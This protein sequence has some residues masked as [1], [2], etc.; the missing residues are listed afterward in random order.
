MR[1]MLVIAVAR[2][3][4]WNIALELL[5]L[6][7]FPPFFERITAAYDRNSFIFFF[8]FIAID[9]QTTA[10]TQSACGV[11]HVAVHFVFKLNIVI[12][13]FSLKK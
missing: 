10:V 2:F 9:E 8:S 3:D 12:S 1:F 7:L 6:H 13:Q 4:M 11:H 5:W